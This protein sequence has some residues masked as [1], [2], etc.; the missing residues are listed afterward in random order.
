MTTSALLIIPAALRPAANTV[1]AY[2][3]WG[4]ENYTIHLSSDGATLT[5]YGCRTDVT[6]EFMATLLAAGYDLTR[7]GMTVDEIAAVQAVLD[8]LPSAPVIPP[9]AAAV[10]AALD[11]DLSAS[12][13]GIDH[14]RAALAA[15]DL[16]IL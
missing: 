4:P 12:L 3:G 13:W 1:G 15:R 5:H 16:M 9:G 11:I 10:L 8:A 6:A 14:A 2:M 7:A